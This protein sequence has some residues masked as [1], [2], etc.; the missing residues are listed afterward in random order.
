MA[1]TIAGRIRQFPWRKIIPM[2]TST[3]EGASTS[4]AMVQ[5]RR[6]A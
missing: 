2:V 4:S 1:W 5:W 6:M 3:D